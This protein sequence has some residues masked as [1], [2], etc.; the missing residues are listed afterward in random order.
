MVDEIDDSPPPLRSTRRLLPLCDSRRRPIREANPSR[1]SMTADSIEKY[2]AANQLRRQILSTLA[3]NER[4]SFQLTQGI[5]DQSSF[6][7][8]STLAKARTLSQATLGHS[9]RVAWQGHPAQANFLNHPVLKIA[10]YETADCL[11]S[12]YVCLCHLMPIKPSGSHI[13]PVYIM[14][15]TPASLQGRGLSEDLLTYRLMA[16]ELMNGLVDG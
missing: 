1:K 13:Q 2:V 3:R 12:N 6:R 5:R 14:E 16:S 8:P 11:A 9:R 7:T 4:L 15:L 10:E